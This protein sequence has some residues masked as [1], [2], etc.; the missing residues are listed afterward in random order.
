MD[1][2]SVCSFC[3][4][5]LIFFQGE[6]NGIRRKS[7]EKNLVGILKN[8]AHGQGSLK[9]SQ[10]HEPDTEK[11]KDK[12]ENGSLDSKE[13]EGIDNNPS[14]DMQNLGGIRGKTKFYS[15]WY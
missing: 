4:L 2:I 15:E 12:T 13:K 3:F 14:N 9:R 8:G 1:G 5:I 7:S 11:P 10:S 6:I